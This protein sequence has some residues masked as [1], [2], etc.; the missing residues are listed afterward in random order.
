MQTEERRH[1][2]ETRD[3]ETGDRRRE[4]GDGRQETGDGRQETGEGSL[5]SNPKKLAL[6]VRG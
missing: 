4:T 2:Q 3:G 6:S 1:R 5:T